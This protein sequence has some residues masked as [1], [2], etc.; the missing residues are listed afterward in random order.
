MKYFLHGF[1]KTKAL[2]CFLRNSK[3][4]IVVY[5]DW[6]SIT[7]TEPYAIFSFSRIWFIYLYWVQELQNLKKVYWC[8]YLKLYVGK[9]MD[10]FLIYLILNVFKKDSI[11]CAK[12]SLNLV[13]LENLREFLFEYLLMRQKN[14][15]LKTQTYKS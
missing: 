10:F 2:E 13:F 14:K 6:L 15:R 9:I 7:K 5:C 1:K 4:V 8:K 3:N 11:L 12:I